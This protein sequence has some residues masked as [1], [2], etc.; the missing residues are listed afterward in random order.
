MMS[1]VGVGTAGKSK[2]GVKVGV[3]EKEAVKV[4]PKEREK[5]EVEWRVLLHNDEVHTFDYVSRKLAEVRPNYQ[6]Q[7]KNR[8]ARESWPG[9]INRSIDRSIDGCPLSTTP[10][11]LTDPL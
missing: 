9:G 8:R 7:H 3:K 10:E 2:A 4:S 11:W 1:D 6:Q 5:F